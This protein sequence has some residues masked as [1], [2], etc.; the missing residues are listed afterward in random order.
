MPIALVMTVYPGFQVQLEQDLEPHKSVML[1]FD[2]RVNEKSLRKAT[3]NSNV[4]FK[5]M[6]GIQEHV[7]KVTQD[8]IK[9]VQEFSVDALASVNSMLDDFRDKVRC[10]I[11]ARPSIIASAK[12]ARL[13]R[14]LGFGALLSA[15]LLGCVIIPQIHAPQQMKLPVYAVAGVLLLIPWLIALKATEKDLVRL[16]EKE[17]VDMQCFSVPTFVNTHTGNL[18]ITSIDTNGTFWNKENQ[19]SFNRTGFQVARAAQ[20]FGGNAAG[21]EVAAVLGVV[22]YTLSY[23]SKPKAKEVYQDLLER[24]EPKFPNRSIIQVIHLSGIRS[25]SKLRQRNMLARYPNDFRLTEG[26]F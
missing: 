13:M 3:D 12:R 1:F 20:T 15:V 6:A 19:T 23:F 4:H 24:H 22:N 9:T 14:W 26:E 17:L 2:K 10:E 18:T 5:Q 7:H 25:P 11:M 21:L 16:A 8:F